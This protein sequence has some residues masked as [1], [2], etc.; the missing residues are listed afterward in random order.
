[1]AKGKFQHI[2][3]IVFNKIIEIDALHTVH[4]SVCMCHFGNIYKP[5][6]GYLVRI[7]LVDFPNNMYIFC[8]SALYFKMF[9]LKY[10]V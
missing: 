8:F 9:R 4:I 5:K 1:M 6:R 2:L 7:I 10:P 3:H